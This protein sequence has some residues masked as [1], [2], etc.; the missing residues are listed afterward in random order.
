MLFLIIVFLA[1]FSSMSVDIRALC[2][3]E[4]EPNDP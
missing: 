1:L 3:L 4:S 2:Q